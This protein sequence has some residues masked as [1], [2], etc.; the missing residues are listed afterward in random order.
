MAIKVVHVLD[1]GT[2]VRVKGE[3][4]KRYT[5]IDADW[6]D[7]QEVDRLWKIAGKG[8][9]ERIITRDRLVVVSRPV[10]RR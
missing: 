5:V 9:G 10:R 1:A 8:A 6:K 2:Q 3:R 7:G 4:G